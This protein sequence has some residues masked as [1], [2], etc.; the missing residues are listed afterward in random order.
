MRAS[1]LDF[2]VNAAGE[3]EFHQSVNGF[4][5]GVVDVDQ[6]F[7]RRELELFAALFVNEGRT[8]NGE[9][10]LVGGQGYGT[11]D[12]STRSLDGLYDLLGAFVNQVV[13]VRFQ[14]D[15]DFLAHI[16]LSVFL[17][18]DWSELFQQVYAALAFG[19]NVLGNRA[20]NFGIV[21]EAHG[22]GCAA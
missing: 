18:K 20:G 4:V 21:A 15:S 12:D 6:A 8:V 3:L 14:F 1:D 2:N 10:A 11:A 19:Q 7:E 13:V 9:D 16:G 17:F 5:G 22:R